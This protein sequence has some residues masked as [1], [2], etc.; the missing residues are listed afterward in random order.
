MSI[1]ESTAEI[2]TESVES[3]EKPRVTDSQ[4]DYAEVVAALVEQLDIEAAEAKEH[5]SEVGRD[6]AA[7]EAYIAQRFTSGAEQ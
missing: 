7:A 5:I 3:P 2:A 4:E 1:H 6:A